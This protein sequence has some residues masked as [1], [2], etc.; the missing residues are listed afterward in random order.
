MIILIFRI[1]KHIPDEYDLEKIR[2]FW[3]TPDITA[4]DQKKYIDD[5]QRASKNVWIIIAAMLAA[6]LIFSISYI[7]CGRIFGGLLSFSLLAYLFYRGKAYDWVFPIG[8]IVCGAASWVSALAGVAP[9]EFLPETAA[10]A[11]F[12]IML[13]SVPID[14]LTGFY[15]MYSK[16]INAYVKYVEY[17]S[18]ME[19]MK[20]K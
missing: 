15:F 4:A 19:E 1:E 18:L 13:I 2:K 12:I 17:I 10:N 3:Q 9:L 14:I 20:E 7:L 5:L 8:K 16:K 11:A 6:G